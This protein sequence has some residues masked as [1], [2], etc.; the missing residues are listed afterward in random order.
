M[1]LQAKNLGSP[2]ETRAFTDKGRLD[3]VKLGDITVGRG[4]FEP[5]WKWSEH[6]KSLAKT[7]S[8]ESAHLGY[9]VSGRMKIVMDDGTETEAGPGD[10]VSIPPGHDAWIVGDETCVFIDFQGFAEYARK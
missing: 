6:V 9:M 1:E 5:G 3:V 2:E 7:D 4:V 10:A 8:C